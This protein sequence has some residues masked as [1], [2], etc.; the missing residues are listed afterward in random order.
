MIFVKKMHHKILIQQCKIFESTVELSQEYGQVCWN[1]YSSVKKEIIFALKNL[2]KSS[3]I[4]IKALDQGGIFVGPLKVGITK[5]FEFK[6][7]YGKCS[8]S[9]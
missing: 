5:A 1:K 6:Y 9:T 4:P 7:R 3:T 2:Y 8:S